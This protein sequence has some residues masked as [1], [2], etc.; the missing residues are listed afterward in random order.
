MQ[1]LER[2]VMQ[3]KALPVIAF[4]LALGG[5]AGTLDRMQDAMPRASDFRISSFE[6]N[7]YSKE[8]AVVPNTF[9]LQPVTPADYVNADGSCAEV[10]ATE[11]TEQSAVPAVGLQMTECAAV[12]VL[13]APEKVDIGTNERGER[14]VKLTYTRGER[15]GLYSFT[16]GRLKE[17]ERVAEP[18][19]PPKPQ[20]PQRKPAQPPRRAT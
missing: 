9:K 2:K 14:L 15:A 16:A 5:C 18:A 11:G 10:T 7:P 19:P 13:G 17:V 1:R 6:W 20:K 4:A 3:G 12:R 8:S